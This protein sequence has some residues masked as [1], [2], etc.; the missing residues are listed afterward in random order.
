MS[1]TLTKTRNVTEDKES[2][3]PDIDALV[4]QHWNRICWVVFRLVGDWD[5]AQDI[6]L[7]T[8]LQLHQNPP[9]HAENLEGWLYRV[10]SNRG[11]NAQ[12]SRGRRTYYED[13][14]AL[15]DNLEAQSEDPADILERA[16]E[17]AL[18]RVVLGEMQPRSA[19]L[20]VLRYSGLT[21]AELAQV[22]NVSKN[23]IGTLLRR[24]ED[25]FEKVFIEQESSWKEEQ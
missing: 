5:E 2:V 1:I 12:R 20:L 8:F 6:A 11:L 3:T 10:A 13:Q 7:E 25:E 23:S 14:T 24:A 19:Q 4:Y 18:V 22:F 15:S 17:R 9:R 21:Y 16:Q